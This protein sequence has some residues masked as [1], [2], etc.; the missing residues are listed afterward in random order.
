M[1]LKEASQAVI[2]ALQ[3][4]GGR[5]EVNALAD[6]V[7]R[8]LKSVNGTLVSLGSKGKYAKGLIDYEKIQ[9]G[10]ATV[11]YVFLTDAGVNFV[12]SEETPDAE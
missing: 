8:P 11:K 2:D 1:I 6:A 3:A 9:E 4:A 10:E 5:L 12:P 7:N